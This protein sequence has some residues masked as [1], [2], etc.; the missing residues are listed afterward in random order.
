MLKNRKRLSSR[1]EEEDDNSNP[2]ENLTNLF[3]VMLVFAC[4][5]MVALIMSLNVDV[6]RLDQA[7]IEYKDTS[8]GKATVEE[9]DGL[10]MEEVGTVYRDPE[11]GK[12]YIL[13]DVEEAEDTK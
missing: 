3:D 6:S 12:T 13:D 5:L 4:G 1:Y 2:L 9:A 7:V 11:T 8:G 10:N